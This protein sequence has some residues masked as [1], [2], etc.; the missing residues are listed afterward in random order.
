VYLYVNKTYGTAQG[1]TSDGSYTQYKGIYTADPASDYLSRPMEMITALQAAA[2]I[3]RPVT[4]NEMVVG[5]VGLRL[6]PW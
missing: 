6:N 3:L 1:Y 4:A 5:G 2:P